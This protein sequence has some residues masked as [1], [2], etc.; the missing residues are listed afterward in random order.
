M[1]MRP[2]RHPLLRGIWLSLMLLFLLPM[3]PGKAAGE[4]LLSL[5]TEEAQVGE[6][7]DVTVQ[8]GEKA[9]S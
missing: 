2:G 3:L 5:S 7:V 6:V 4:M 1:K 8:A 9:A